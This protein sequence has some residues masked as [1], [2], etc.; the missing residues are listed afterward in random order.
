MA[1]SL[2]QAS[3]PVFLRYLARLEGLV[4]AAQSHAELG[5][6]DAAT[7]LTARLAPDMLPFEAQ[8]QTA[9]NFALRTCYPLVGQ[10]IAPYGD[11]PATFTGLRSRIEHVVALLN[12]L[13]PAEFEGAES[14][15]LESKAGGAV[16]RLAAPEFVLHYALPNFFFHVTVAFA[17]L[18]NCGVAIG[19]EDFDGL[20]SY[21]LQ[22]GA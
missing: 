11:F 15:I 21:A 8:V 1:I 17:I 16:V 18:R 20:H 22:D 3:V 7:L 10:S 14:R 12:A 13:P 5:Q 6:L 2:Y 19:K 9:T 4:S